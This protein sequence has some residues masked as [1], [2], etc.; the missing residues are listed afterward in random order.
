MVGSVTVDGGTKVVV[1]FMSN[2]AF[3]PDN[4]TGLEENLYFVRK[5]EPAMLVTG[6]EPG[7]TYD[8]ASQI[9]RIGTN[10]SRLQF[11]FDLTDSL[12]T[13]NDSYYLDP[14]SGATAYN[15]TSLIISAYSTESLITQ[16]NN[17]S[18]YVEMEDLSGSYKIPHVN[19]SITWSFV[20]GDAGDWSLLTAE[21]YQ[22]A[23][24]QLLL[25]AHEDVYMVLPVIEDPITNS[26]ISDSVMAL[27]VAH[28]ATASTSQY[29]TPRIALTYLN[30]AY[31]LGSINTANE[32]IQQGTNSNRSYASGARSVFTVQKAGIPNL[33]TGILEYS[34]AYFA[35]AIAG[36]VAN[37]EPAIPITRKN[38]VVSGLDVIFNP[39]EQETLIDAGVCFATINQNSVYVVRGI[40]SLTSN[41]V[42]REISVVHIIDNVS[43]SVKEQIRNTYIGAVIEGDILSRVKHTV[44]QMLATMKRSA[45]QGGLISESRNTRVEQ[46]LTDKTRVNIYFEMV[47]KLPFNFAYITQYVTDEYQYVSINGIELGG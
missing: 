6:V 45:A 33:V 16:V 44:E 9:L 7:N 36:M 14:T 18:Q 22:T 35:A 17:A 19:N 46:D 37:S 42:Q 40:N 12:A 41:T 25:P 47:P 26:S 8:V 27:A 32:N 29:S 15:G 13:Y 1:T 28:C 23:L 43:V 2:K 11:S 24:N 20:D 3:R 4:V 34:R 10:G 38:M 5:A 31:T 39:A 21:D 30:E